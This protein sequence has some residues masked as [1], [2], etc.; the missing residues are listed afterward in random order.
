MSSAGCDS[1]GTEE[2]SRNNA[3]Y[4]QETLHNKLKYD[5]P[6]THHRDL[7]QLRL[8]HTRHLQE[9]A[10]ALELHNDVLLRLHCLIERVLLGQLRKQK[11]PVRRPGL[12][13]R[14]CD[15]EYC[16]L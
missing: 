6:H 5:F 16:I 12:A 9:P 10:L 4:T 15:A 14:L 7:R 13:P 1:V 2:I 8:G 3:Q 11:F